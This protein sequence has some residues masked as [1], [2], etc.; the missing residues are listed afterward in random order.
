M[1]LPGNQHLHFFKVRFSIKMF[2]NDSRF[3]VK[4][5]S[6]EETPVEDEAGTPVLCSFPILNV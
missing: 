5:E 1:E 4:N 3:R 6:E 2:K